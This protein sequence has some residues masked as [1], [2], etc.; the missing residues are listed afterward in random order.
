MGA[1]G[2]FLDLGAVDADRLGIGKELMRE[3]A[4][5]DDFGAGGIGQIVRNPLVQEVGAARAHEGK[6]PQSLVRFRLPG[7]PPS[8]GEPTDWRIDEQNDLAAAHSPPW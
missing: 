5:R 8:L 6:S 7:N 2:I 1:A 4:H 3:F